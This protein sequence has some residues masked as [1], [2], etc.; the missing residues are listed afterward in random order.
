MIRVGVV[1]FGLAGRVFHAPLI[2]SV[3]GLE[4]SGIVER[5]GDT[6]A[7]RYPGV[8]IHRAF[9]EMLA[10][11]SI[12]LLV[13]AT[14]SGSHFKLAKQAIESGRH[15]IVDKPVATSSEEVA[16]LIRSA[17]ERGVKLI[18]FHNRRWDGD[19]LTLS[20]L[21]KDGTLGRLV[22]LESRMDRWNPGATRKP[23]KNDASL[24]GGLL[25]DLGT[26]LADQALTL[27]G[28]PVAVWSDVLRERE[29][30]GA[31]DA[32]TVGLRYADGLRVTLG[33]NALSSPAGARFHLRGTHGN[34]RKKGIDPQEAA[35]SKVTRIDD[36]LWGRE[37]REDWGMLHVDVDGGKVTQPLET[38]S[39]NY[40]RFYEGVRDALAEKA[41]LPVKPRDA[42]QVSRL[43]EWAQA[44]S[45]SRCEVACDWN[46]EPE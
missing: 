42:W 37:P 20:K 13:I 10:D 36:S 25:L 27:F 7:Q 3:D 45:V 11:D 38:A 44:S 32:F 15:V 12:D 19:F 30:E 16:R 40:R 9:E 23:W 17:R 8:K 33:A 28:K 35:L 24:G 43:L 21:V 34:Y 1:G 46:G 4:L 29:G 41:E 14:P 22:H 18:P 5:S 6:A 39:G 2:S 26:H 31:E